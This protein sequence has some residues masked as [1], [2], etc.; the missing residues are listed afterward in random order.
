M[1]SSTLRSDLLRRDIR[2]ALLELLEL[3]EFPIE[4]YTYI[5]ILVVMNMAMQ[6]T[7]YIQ[8]FNHKCISKNRVL[9]ARL[10]EI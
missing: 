1:P 3:L 4:C 6:D 7:S 5:L 8:K 2:A 9:L 10:I